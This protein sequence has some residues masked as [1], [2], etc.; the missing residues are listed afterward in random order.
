MDFKSFVEQNPAKEYFEQLSHNKG[1]KVHQDNINT[2]LGIIPVTQPYE[3]IN[4]E[5]FNEYPV[6]ARVKNSGLIMV[7]SYAGPHLTSSIISCMLNGTLD[8]DQATFLLYYKQFYSAINYNCIE[9]LSTAVIERMSS[10]VS[11]MTR[12]QTST[13]KEYEID[14][15]YLVL[16]AFQ[17]QIELERFFVEAN[18][19]R[20]F[21]LRDQWS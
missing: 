17:K 3:V 12:N 11:L 20:I 21:N 7:D 5:P 16:E 1:Y 14:S 10:I 9:S 15:L 2:S 13:Y 18:Q 6:I 4:I 19:T 8:I